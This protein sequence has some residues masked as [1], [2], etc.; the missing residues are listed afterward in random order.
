MIDK[1]TP[2]ATLFKLKAPAILTRRSFLAATAKAGLA[3]ALGASTAIMPGCSTFQGSSGAN[4]QAL[5]DQPQYPQPIDYPVHGIDVSRFQHDINWQAVA[6]S[7][8]RFVWLKAT[9]G[10]DHL[11]EKFLQNWDGAARAGI[12]RGAYHFCYW[13]RPPHEEIGWFIKNVPKDPH[14]LPPV[15]DTEATPESKS[16]KRVLYREE[17]RADMAKM[18]VLMEEAY[19]RRPVIYTTVDFYASILDPDGFLD[20]PMWVR[21]TK[22]YPA[23]KYPGREWVFWQ[24]QSDG[25]I[26]GIQGKVDRNAFYGT[27]EAWQNFLNN[28][29]K[30]PA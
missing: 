6:S 27:E 21:S 25:L 16:C 17:V 14:A 12:P 8:V 5:N 15:L 26:P 24:Y 4:G 28:K 10:G 3:T 1:T 22:Y 29:P 9:E 13:C 11:D 20:Y 18:L 7:G 23:V 2:A 19:G 30:K